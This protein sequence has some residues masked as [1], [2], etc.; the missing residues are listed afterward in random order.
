MTHLSWAA[1]V[2]DYS[3][4]SPILTAEAI[5]S[6]ISV[7]LRGPL[8]AYNRR[9]HSFHPPAYCLTASSLHRYLY[10]DS[11]LSTWREAA[12]GSR[13]STQR[14]KS[15]SASDKSSAVSKSRILF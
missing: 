2:S 6:S 10:I 9:S 7:S 4:V 8:Y 14:E 3:L 5:V 11:C 15:A 13:S 1:R 12:K